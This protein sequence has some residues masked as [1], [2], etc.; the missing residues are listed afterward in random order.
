MLLVPQSSQVAT[1][2]SQRGCQN[3]GNREGAHSTRQTKCNH[4]W[5]THKQLET[6]YSGGAWL[7]LP[8]ESWDA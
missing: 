4:Y 3:L 5:F 6:V 8:V 7:A 2:P 1:P